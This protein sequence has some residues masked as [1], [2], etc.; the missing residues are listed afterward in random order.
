MKIPVAYPPCTQICIG[1]QVGLTEL[2]TYQLPVTTQ[3]HTRTTN[4]TNNFHHHHHHHHHHP[5]FLTLP[6][7]F[8]LT[9]HTHSYTPIQFLFPAPSLFALP[10]CVLCSHCISN[11]SSLAHTS[12]ACFAL[13]RPVFPFRVLPRKQYPSYQQLYH[14]LRQS[15]S[16]LSPSLLLQPMVNPP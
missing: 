13:F 11:F 6:P 14:I 1:T 5:F 9:T 3:I 8:H 16:P 12:V 2:T 7:T 15:L 4:V 10:L